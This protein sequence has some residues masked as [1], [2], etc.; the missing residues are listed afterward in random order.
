MAWIYLAAVTVAF[1]WNAWRYSKYLDN[2]IKA[3]T[4]RMFELSRQWQLDLNRINGMARDDR[5]ILVEIKALKT[6]M[7]ALEAEVRRLSNSAE[8]RSH[9][10]SQAAIK[11]ILRG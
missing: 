2:A 6:R 9:E 7:S 4:E 8:Q 1:G 5:E 10:A 11:D 3:L